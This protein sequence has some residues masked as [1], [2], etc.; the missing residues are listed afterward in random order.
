M[1][2]RLA[3][4]LALVLQVL[5]S[6]APAEAE[7]PGYSM[8]TVARYEVDA[9]AGEV[10]VTVEVA[11]INTTPNP[12]GQVSGFDRIDLGVHQ[13]A[14]QLAAQDDKGPLTVEMVTRDGVQVASVRPRAR[15]RYNRSVSFTLT[16][17][18]ADGS[19]PDLHV[20]PEAIKFAAWGFGTSSEVT[21][22][23][24][25]GY[26][27]RADG[28]PMLIDT[29][30]ATL[31]MTSGTIPDP[32][33]WLALITATR[34]STYA[35]PLSASVA[36]ASG[37]VDLQVRAWTDDAA[38]GSSTLATLVDGL[39]KLEAAL[40]L[41]YPRVGPLVVS[42][43]VGGEGIPGQGPQPTAEMQVAFDADAF[44]LL[45]QAAHIW[46]GDQLASDRWLREGLA[47]HAAG[48]VAASFGAA[49]PYDP[50]AR[51]VE[52]AA[53]AFPL[54][55]WSAAST[56]SARDAYAYAASWAAVN[57]VARVAGEANVAR[58]LRRVVAGVTAYDPIDADQLGLTGQRFVPVD[59]RRFLDQLAAASGLDLPS[60]IG[61]VALGPGADPELAQRAVARDA[62]R[63]LLRLAGDWGVPEPIRNAMTAWHFADAQS[64]MEMAS[65]WLAQRDALITKVTRAGLATPDQL[66][67]QFAAV[68][69][70]APAQSEL[71]AEGAV[72]DAYLEIQARSVTRRGPL[73]TIGLFGADD[74]RTLLARAGTDFAKGDLQAAAGTLDAAEVQL[75][76]APANGVVRIAAAVVLLV[77]IF[78]FWSLNA[79]RRGGT[80]YT[81]A[82]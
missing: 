1:I 9:T 32:A 40:G 74:P 65:A 78:L 53:D 46:I 15:V 80:H 68:G 37:T 59:T 61:S 50:E 64:G 52:L 13:G 57:R 71:A 44:T 58:A 73:E 66:R 36:L 77:V 28:D 26:E 21:V 42:E 27:A 60:M 18:L 69:G 8:S 7:G 16:Y 12:P 54:V 56:I 81:S 55:D 20:R 75:N 45:H 31:S 35:T 17:H 11:F 10:V 63:D 33:S 4:V 22:E 23:L 51:V 72:V 25:L 24:P 49:L 19:A 76:R 3:V 79:R 67:E 48:T 6:P 14:A 39:P 41:P 62:Y 38:W 82:G 43:A 5:G 30:G 29:G 70:G 2:R 34:P 47:S